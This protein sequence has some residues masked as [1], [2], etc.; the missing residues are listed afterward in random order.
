M[1]LSSDICVKFYLPQLGK[2][3]EG[4]VKGQGANRIIMEEFFF[5]GGEEDCIKLHDE[6][7]YDI[8]SRQI[9]LE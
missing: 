5:G 9:L 7:L 2:N 3:I 8:I 4:G 6:E 1:I